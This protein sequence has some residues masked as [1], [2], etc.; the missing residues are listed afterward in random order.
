MTLIVAITLTLIYKQK[1]DEMM[2]NLDKKRT[3]FRQQYH[4][5]LVTT[6]LISVS[7]VCLQLEPKYT[8]QLFYLKVEEVSD[9]DFG[10]FKILN[11]IKNL[12]LLISWFIS[13]SSN[14]IQLGDIELEPDDGEE[15]VAG[16]EDDSEEQEIVET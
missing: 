12:L 10:K 7:W 6:C 15:E 2:R 5:E 4:I 14:G 3:E 8:N 16:Q 13:S 11:Y 9:S 1:A